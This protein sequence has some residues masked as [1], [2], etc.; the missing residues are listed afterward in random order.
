[1]RA[2]IQLNHIHLQRGSKPLLEDASMVLH[3]GQRGAIVGI[4]GCGK[5]TLLALL[6]GRIQLDAGELYLPPDWRIAHMEQDIHDPQRPAR[7]YI[8]DGHRP[9]RRLQT[10]IAEAELHGRHE[11]LASLHAELD[12]IDGYQ[13]KHRAETIML[14]LGFVS[15]D[16]D[17]PVG[18]FSGGWRIR[19]NLAR[20]LL[21]PSDVLL[22]D[23]PTN[24]LDLEAIHWLEQWLRQ[25]PGSVLL[26]SHDR[27]FIDATVDRIFHI[28][29]LQIDSYSGS[30][31][32]F[33]RQR[34][35]RLVLQQSLYQKQQ[36]R[37]DELQQFIDRFRAKASKAK[38]AQSR[39]KALEKMQ[40]ITP[41]RDAS[42]YH[43]TIR[44]AD[45][46]ASPLINGFDV[47]CGYNGNAVLQHCMLSIT[48][49]LRLGLLGVNGAGKSTLIKT[50]AG[51]LPPV[52]GE[53]TISEFC[54]IGYFAQ[55]Q[56]EALD[57][58]ASPLLHLQRLSPEAREQDLRNFLGSFRINGDMAV[59]PVAPF[60]GGEKARL[61]LAIIAWQKPNLLLLD[62]P[63]NHLDLEMREALAEALQSFQGAMILV[64]HD[65]YLLRHCVDEFL[66]VAD[67]EARSF[68]GELDDY[69]RWQQARQTASRA[70]ADDKPRD[71]N[72]KQQR[73][74]AAQLR[75]KLAPQKKIIAALEQKIGRLEQALALIEE[76]LADTGLYQD[77]QR[78]R[79]SRLLQDQ[80]R[81]KTELE[82]LEQQWFDEQEKLAELETALAG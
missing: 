82:Q 13:Q 70:R 72:K 24:H 3:S 55:H 65:R 11:Q 58:D 60:S 50:L 5:S 56:L 33:E 71:N 69:Y 40:Q 17:K 42:S 43:F 28:H 47:S 22:L 81:Q 66:L 26:I 9:L 21:C 54:R 19:L 15:T 12:A 63:T 59:S 61:A 80:G 32:D 37:R 36:Q 48:P 52:A 27:D 46:T 35:E 67:G 64:S 79:L 38:Q 77:D 39:I 78:D 23:E 76:Q 31:S 57:L 75:Q 49:G 53:L 45:K 20:A 1:M 51:L 7:D 34:A 25:Y 16:Y 68:D 14:G 74:D 62:E 6:L 8:L 41:V 73:Q 29:N 4:N 18:S 44:E 10:A 2:M 30:Y